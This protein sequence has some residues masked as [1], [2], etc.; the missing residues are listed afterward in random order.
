MVEFYLQKSS[1]R[2]TRPTPETQVQRGQVIRSKS[3]SSVVAE[4]GWKPGVFRLS[5]RMLCS[6]YHMEIVKGWVNTAHK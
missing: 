3:H 2:L 6:L 5:A 4:P 1:Y